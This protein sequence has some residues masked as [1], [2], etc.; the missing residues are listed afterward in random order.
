[1]PTSLSVAEIRE[2]FDAWQRSRTARE[3]EA[4]EAEQS[5]A[6]GKGKLRATDE[7]IEAHKAEQLRYEQGG[8]ATGSDS[9][10]PGSGGMSRKLSDW[11]FGANSNG[12]NGDVD[13][14]VASLDVL[15]VSALEG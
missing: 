6:M 9:P 13:D 3:M 15:G 11:G 5:A 1:V 4:R 12:P 10:G 8:V 14:R 2:S 7:E